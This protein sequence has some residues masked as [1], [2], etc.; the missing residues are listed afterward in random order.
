MVR[1]TE[2]D[3]TIFGFLQARWLEQC[4]R[5]AHDF[6]FKTTVALDNAQVWGRTKNIAEL[7]S[8]RSHVYLGNLHLF[9]GG[10]RTYS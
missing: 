3:V 6:D 5:L 7:G 1:T 10:H 9:L 4:N 8:R 2:L